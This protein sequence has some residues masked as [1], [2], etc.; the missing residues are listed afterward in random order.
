[1]RDT[2]YHRNPREIRNMNPMRPALTFSAL[3][4]A[5]GLA[6]ASPAQKEVHFDVP[7]QPLNIA[8]N[9]LAQQAGLKIV[10][11]TGEVGTATSRPVKGS[12]TPERALK[13]LLQ[14]Q[15]LTYEFVGDTTVAVTPPKSA[16]ATEA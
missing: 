8:L 10:F 4:L 7:A 3:C 5:A 12:L 14:N 9:A 15:R 11:N 13:L 16:A 2:R 1:Q 6:L